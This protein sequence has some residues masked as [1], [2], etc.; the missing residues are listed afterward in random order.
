MLNILQN[1]N[2][3][4]L[5]IDGKLKPGLDINSNLRDLAGFLLK[6][7]NITRS[8]Y[9]PIKFSLNDDIYKDFELRLADIGIQKNCFIIVKFETFSTFPI[10]PCTREDRNRNN[11][12]KDGI[13]FKL[14]LRD[15]LR[16]MVE[17]SL[18]NTR[19]TGVDLMEIIKYVLTRT[20]H[21]I[22]ISTIQEK[23]EEIENL[24][25]SYLSGIKRI[26]KKLFLL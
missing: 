23:I 22:E 4:Y 17:R 26:L 8:A 15:K 9:G 19:K 21:P 1:E 12:Y 16:F 11:E 20:D 24:N 7:F 18:I 2:V 10:G 13:L 3:F 25:Q 5:V 14:L 6:E